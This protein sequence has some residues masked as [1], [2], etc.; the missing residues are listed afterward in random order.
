MKT[1]NAKNYSAAEIK[2][3]GKYV[4]KNPD[5]LQRAFRLASEELEGRTAVN[6][7]HTYYRRNSKVAIALS[8]NVITL[9]NKKFIVGRK[10][11]SNRLNTSR[12]LKSQFNR[13]LS[14]LENG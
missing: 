10:N 13:I 7:S 14:I 9:S 3:I 6:I 5:N 8:K 11:S 1:K 4:S 2:I 12:L